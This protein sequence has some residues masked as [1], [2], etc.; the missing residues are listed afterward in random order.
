M[1]YCIPIFYILLEQDQG[2]LNIKS[3]WP[4]KQKHPNFKPRKIKKSQRKKIPIFHQ[5][6]PLC[7]TF[8]F[9]VNI[10]GFCWKVR[11]KNFWKW[12]VNLQNVLNS[13]SV[14]LKLHSKFQIDISTNSLYP[15]WTMAN[16]HKWP[17][18]GSFGA[19]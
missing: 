7:Q 6:I 10:K 18:S 11:Y 4:L 2:M 14:Y 5:N 15:I 3:Y 1:P 17:W 16:S 13:C 8:S 12:F 19:V 9:S